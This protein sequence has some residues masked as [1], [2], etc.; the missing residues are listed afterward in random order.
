MVDHMLTF[1]I[2]MYRKVD[3]LIIF[4]RRSNGWGNFVILYMCAIFFY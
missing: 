1:A 2:S 4:K 3:R